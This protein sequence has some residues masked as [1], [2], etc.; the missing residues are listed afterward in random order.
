MTRKEYK[1]HNELVRIAIEGSV[2]VG[3]S[4][5]WL[6]WGAD[7]CL[8]YGINKAGFKFVWAMLNFC[9]ATKY[10][11]DY[12]EKKLDF[13]MLVEKEVDDDEEE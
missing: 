3:S 7:T 12:K 2:W 6:C 5:M 8:D 11:F 13:D 9:I 10:Y 1:L 4:V